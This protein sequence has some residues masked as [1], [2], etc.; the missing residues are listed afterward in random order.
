M[1]E[2]HRSVIGLLHPGEMGSAVGRCLIGRDYRVLW[3]SHGRGPQTAARAGA[4]GL[5]D[6]G[7]VSQLAA[8]ADVIISVCPPHA[9]LDLA[10]AVHGFSGTYADANAVSPPT[11]RE[12]ASVVT[13]GGP[14]SLDA[15]IN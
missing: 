6:A 13:T 14:S 3:A 7:T 15:G 9:A 5:A 1:E 11:A 12:I 10:R 8:Q 4:A 2:P